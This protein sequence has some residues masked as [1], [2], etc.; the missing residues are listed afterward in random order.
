MAGRPASLRPVLVLL[1]HAAAT[2]FM[3]GL[4]WF[5]QVVHY[6]LFAEV[7][8]AAPAGSDPWPAYAAAHVRRTTWVVGPPMLLEAACSVLLVAAPPEGVP[9]WMTWIGVGLLAVV[10]L[11]TGLL[12]VPAH[13]RLAHAFDAEVHRRLVRSS[14]LRTAGWTAR[15]ALALAMIPAAAAAGGA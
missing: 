11:S 4:A 2:L 14:W 6:P 8:P 1:V 5:V 7:A 10:W 9:A 15:G 13:G 12:Q 3:A